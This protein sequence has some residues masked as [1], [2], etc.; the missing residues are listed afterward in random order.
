M[1]GIY[2]YCCILLICALLPSIARA[3][4]LYLE[5]V[6][7]GKP[8]AIVAVNQVAS[9][10]FIPASDLRAFGVKL[11]DATL[12]FVEVTNIKG[13]S[14]S[15]DES[16]QR[17][18]VVL[19]PSYLPEQ[20]IGKAKKRE[21]DVGPSDFGMVLN[22][23]LFTSRTN[24]DRS[25]NT[26]V[27]HELVA[28]YSPAFLTSTGMYRDDQ[29]NSQSKD[30]IR[31][32]T[33]WQYD[34]PDQLW[35]LSLGDV[36]NGGNY[37]TRSLRMGGVRFSRDYSIDPQFITYPVPEFLGEA[38]L[39]SSIEL[40]INDRKRAQ[41][42]VEP[43]PYIVDVP[44][45]ISGAG[46]AQLVTTDIQG[47][48]TVEQ[49]NF[50]VS[51]RLLKS[52]LFD[53]D[54]TLGYPREA[55][56]L[57]S[58]AYADDLAISGRLRYGL[59]DWFTPELVT[60]SYQDLHLW[61]VGSTGKLG[62]WGVLELSANHS[63][64]NKTSA[65]QK[66]VG[67]QY[68]KGSFGVALRNI[69]R[70]RGYADLSQVG[71][72][73]PALR[74]MQ[75]SFSFSHQEMGHFNFGYFRFDQEEKDF[76]SM[77]MAT[78][79]VLSNSSLANTQEKSSA[80]LP[81]NFLPGYVY[82]E[83]RKNEFIS[84]TWSRGFSSGLNLLATASRDLD[85]S[86]FDWSFSLSFPLEHAGYVSASRRHNHRGPDSK[87]IALQQNAPYS[88]GLGWHFSYVDTDP[89]GYHQMAFNWRND[90]TNAAIGS[91][92]SN[93]NRNYCV[94]LDGS[95]VLMDWNLFAAREIHDSFALVD[96]SIPD[97]PVYA[98]Q[99]LAG[100]TN[101]WGKVL[102]TDLSAY[103][104][105]KISLDPLKL[106]AQTVFK[107]TEKYVIP[108]RRGGVKLSFPLDTT[109]AALVVLVDS[110]GEF[111]PVG[112]E[113]LLKRES[114]EKQETAVVGWDGEVFIQSFDQPVKLT[115]ADGK[116]STV[117]VPLPSLNADL[118]RI[119]PLTCQTRR[120][121]KP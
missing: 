75:A 112:T 85:S 34:H 109:Q 32:E 84:L 31:F 73:N 98:G 16:L 9:K 51:S 103:V 74:E 52:S 57:R 87:Q 70:D 108:S 117:A 104:E 80:N 36:I 92:G 20:Y 14:V 5:L 28:F 71:G 39:P 95:L 110:N 81:T 116:C 61:G 11:P 100:H 41:E 120:S 55:F 72:I 25:W 105:N 33:R 99:R 94:G 62:L 78:S 76:T 79:S 35:T 86:V 60:Q 7:N 45:Y 22:Y 118:P 56:G 40:L 54:L 19:P 88:G 93:L 13:A 23:D 102:L 107:T 49:I 59:T 26:S 10:W 2:L 77:S 46:V 21:R 119:G 53:Y 42:T 44:T 37:W 113:I 83:V 12:G 38:A 66:G 64:F 68:Q 43:G 30:Y 6:I 101:R 82:N 114:A 90:Y 50:Y 48:R 17:L 91:Y 29:A 115:W 97:V 47:R 121:T 8:A 15:Y 24:L 67:Y 63:D 4:V 18:N 58:D 3:E 111:L 89:V 27:W 65:W 1:A 106:P 96:A 69:V